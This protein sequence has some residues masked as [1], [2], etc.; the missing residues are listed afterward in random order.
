MRVVRFVDA[1]EGVREE[2]QRPQWGLL[3][4]DAVYP[5][6]RPPYAEAEGERVQS[7]GPARGA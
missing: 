3:V 7:F 2:W 5:L 6:D 1:I 4:G